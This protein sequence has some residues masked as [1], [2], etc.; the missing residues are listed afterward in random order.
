MT[1]TFVASLFAAALLAPS[2]PE[3]AP[4]WP[5]ELQ[6][7][8]CLEQGDTVACA[9]MDWRLYS[10]GT[11]IARPDHEGTWTFDPDT[12]HFT[13]TYLEDRDGDGIADYDKRYRGVRI[14]SCIEGEVLDRVHWWRMDFTACR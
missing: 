1:R 6:G 7:S 14:G 10:D 8:E 5:I 3:A 2:A 11:A 13:M 12:G 4:G 9:I